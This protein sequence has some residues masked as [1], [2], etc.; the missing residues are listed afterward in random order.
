MTQFSITDCISDKSPAQYFTR[1]TA[2]ITWSGL[3]DELQAASEDTILNLA[4]S[5][6]K[7]QLDE[8]DAL[9]KAL[10][11][12]RKVDE[13]TPPIEVIDEHL[14]VAMMVLN[15]PRVGDPQS[16]LVKF[17][18]ER[19]RPYDYLIN[20][21]TESLAEHSAM[22]LFEKCSIVNFYKVTESVREYYPHSPLSKAL[23]SLAPHTTFTQD[24]PEAATSA[25]DWLATK[26]GSA[27][28]NAKS[29]CN[30]SIFRKGHS[31]ESSSEQPQPSKATTP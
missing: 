21:M 5:L 11:D 31:V 9:T 3:V 10:V 23:D 20:E 24:L 19:F 4:K 26:I 13:I 6:A 29:L 15:L 22:N 18:E 27:T 8:F 25:K 16:L 2:D 17:S 28:N 1:H 7:C 12:L 30:F 14:A